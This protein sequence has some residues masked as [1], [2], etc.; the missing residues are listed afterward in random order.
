MQFEISKTPH[1]P[2]GLSPLMNPIDTPLNRNSPRM[3]HFN[4]TPKVLSVEQT[5][6]QLGALQERAG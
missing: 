3:K 5:E 1:L 4:Q 6:H 2:S